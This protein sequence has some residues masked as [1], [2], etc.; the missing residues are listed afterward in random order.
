MSYQASI[1]SQFHF[2]QSHWANDPNFPQTSV[3]I[4]PVIGRGG[5]PAQTRLPN[6]GSTAYPQAK[7]FYGF[8]TLKG[9]EY[10]FAPAIGGLKAL[11]ALPLVVAWFGQLRITPRT[12][13]S[14]VAPR[15]QK[16]TS[17]ITI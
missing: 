16:N 17:Q 7:R 13:R 14:G 9:G 4:D 2:M 5:E 8:V 15:P 3:D 1:E 12:A 10:L 11:I 6:Y